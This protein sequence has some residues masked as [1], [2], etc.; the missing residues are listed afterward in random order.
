MKDG[1]LV[2]V[3]EIITEEKGL[4]TFDYMVNERKKADL[5]RRQREEEAAR[6]QEVPAYIIK[7]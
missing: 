1:E 7:A 5:E 2:D 3:K 4:A 6:Q